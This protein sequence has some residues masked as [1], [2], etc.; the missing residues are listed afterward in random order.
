MEHFLGKHGESE[1]FKGSNALV[2][3]VVSSLGKSMLSMYLLQ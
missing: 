2:A 1:L 3:A